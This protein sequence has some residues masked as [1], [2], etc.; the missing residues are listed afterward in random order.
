MEI[1]VYNKTSDI[2]YVDLENS[3]LI[4]NDVAIDYF[5]DRSW[6][7]SRSIASYSSMSNSVSWGAGLSKTVV[8]RPLFE[9]QNLD[10]NVERVSR[11]ASVSSGK[12]MSVTSGQYVNRT[13]SVTTQEKRIVAIPPH[14]KKVFGSPQFVS[15]R[16]LDCDLEKYPKDSVSLSFSESNSPLTIRSYMTYTIGGKSNRICVENGFFV[17]AVINFAEPSI[18]T[19]EKRED[20]CENMKGDNENVEHS[21]G[22]RQVVYD[23]VLQDGRCNSNT[24]FYMQYRIKCEKELYKRS[25]P[26]F[27]WSAYDGGYIKN[28]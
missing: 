8:A 2:L 4:V 21:T 18:Y 26:R 27:K 12:G 15:T 1:S 25:G 14:S 9:Y 11:S 19:Y 22:N 5:G 23:R 28:N 20:V 13:E 24:S 17:S 7:S 6:T 3:F 10:G 16:F